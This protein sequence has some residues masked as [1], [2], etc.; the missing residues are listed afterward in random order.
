MSPL[1]NNGHRGVEPARRQ[2]QQHVFVGAPG[3]CLRGILNVIIGMSCDH[4]GD[5]GFDPS[6]FDGCGRHQ[7]TGEEMF[8]MIV[9]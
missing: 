6:G 5:Y 1:V 7:S 4:I 3:E 2:R 9:L 8:S